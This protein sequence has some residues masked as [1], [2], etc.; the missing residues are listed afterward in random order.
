MT[1]L[2]QIWYCKIGGIDL[3]RLPDGADLPMRKAVEKAYFELTGEQPK[4]NFTGWNAVLDK[5][6]QQVVDEKK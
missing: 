6:E 4:F 1:N 5:Y 2:E 3:S